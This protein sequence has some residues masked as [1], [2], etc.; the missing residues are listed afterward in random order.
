MTRPIPLAPRPFPDE[1]VRSWIGRVAARYD[2]S[3]PAF[4]AQLRDGRAIPVARLASLDWQED[5]A[6]EHLLARATHLDRARIRGLRLVVEDAAK[7]ALWHRSLLAWCPTC[8]CE[9]I[10]RHGETYERAVWHLG[11]CAACPTHRLVLADVC[12]VCAYGRVGFQAVGG[13]QRLVCGLCKRPVDASPDPG[14]GRGFLVDP[15]GRFAL[16]QCAKWTDL[17]LAL[18]AVLLGLTTGS[19]TIGSWQL[20]VP[21]SCIAV[22]VR[23]LAAAL[24][25]PE[26]SGPGPV[27]GKNASTLARDHVFAIL[28]PRAAYEVLG[29]IASVLTGVA[30]RVPLRMPAA[31]IEGLEPRGEVV[32][33]KWFIRRLP[34]D[35]QQWLKARARGWGPILASVVGAAVDIEQESERRAIARRE[36]ARRDDAWLRHA[37]VRYANDARRRIAA[38]AAKR[39]AV[40]LKRNQ[41]QAS[42][43]VRGHLR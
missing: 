4:V 8:A 14:R 23:D 41:D 21:A 34:A 7:P 20:D 39:Q 29:I 28:A 32:D 27:N 36:Q 16:A 15:R 30:G 6:L 24:L 31:Q 43:A 25:W 5:V 42:S 9:D 38:R 11:C 35:E 19:A 26:L 3:P 18:Q 37:T 33:L 2:L 1:S 17:A 13:R 22:E 40:A 12:P 10:A